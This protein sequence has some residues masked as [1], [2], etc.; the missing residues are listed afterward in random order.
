MGAWIGPDPAQAA[1]QTTGGLALGTQTGDEAAASNF[2]DS[3]AFLSWEF[4]PDQW[5]SAVVHNTHATPSSLNG[6]LEVELLLRM[7]IGP[8]HSAQWG[9]TIEYGYE[10]NMG[11]GGSGSGLGYYIQIGRWKDS[12]LF[13]SLV[14][15]SPLTGLGIHEGDVFYAQIVGGV[16]TVK[17]NSTVIASVTDPSPYAHG[18]PG[19]GFFR[20]NIGTPDDPSSYC[21]TSYSAGQL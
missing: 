15:G 1:V 10:I 9:A 5:A 8:S 2:N 6:N 17:L 12:N 13:D 4:P 11:Q 21:F 14:S 3:H 19:V 16:I 20:H 18:A 7:S